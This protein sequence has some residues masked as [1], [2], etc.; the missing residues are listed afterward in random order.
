MRG[1][2]VTGIRPRPR[3]LTCLPARRMTAP[4]ASASVQNP[5]RPPLAANLDLGQVVDPSF[6]QVISGGPPG[7]RT[8]N[9]R[10]KRSSRDAER[11]ASRSSGR[12]ELCKWWLCCTGGS[13]IRSH[14]D[15]HSIIHSRQP[16]RRICRCPGN[17]AQATVI[18]TP[19]RYVRWV[20]RHIPQ[21]GTR[22]SARFIR[23]RTRPSVPVV[24][25]TTLR[26]PGWRSPVSCKCARRG[27][28]PSWA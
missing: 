2:G 21:H 26:L 11:S 25:R 6:P 13:R 23:P 9:P 10:I 12:Y 1:V 3:C 28:T 14:R 17:P 15:C 20:S 8:P 7:D 19:H 18:E 27:W 5:A 4:L 16:N 22:P 24:W